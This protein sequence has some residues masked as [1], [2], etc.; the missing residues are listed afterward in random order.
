MLGEKLYADA[1]EGGANGGD[2]GEDVHAVAL[3]IHHA[4]DTRHLSG[5]SFEASRELLARV[6]FVIHDDNIPPRGIIVKDYLLDAP[7]G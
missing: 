3:L 6:R 5:D 2:L 1:I 4:L 7:A